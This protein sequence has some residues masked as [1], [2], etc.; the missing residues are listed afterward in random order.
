MIRDLA[1]LWVSNIPTQ[2]IRNIA[3]EEE[4]LK[5]LS[6]KHYIDKYSTLRKAQEL[7]LTV[8]ASDLTIDELEIFFEIHGVV[9][10][11]GK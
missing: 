6:H 3:G 5:A 2:Q 4:Y 1:N 9:N 11:N 10:K 8:N 7:G